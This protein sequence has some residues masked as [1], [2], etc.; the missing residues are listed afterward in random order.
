MRKT[1]CFR[2]NGRYF[3]PVLPILMLKWLDAGCSCQ[4]CKWYWSSYETSSKKTSKFPKC[5][6]I[7]LIKLD[8]RDEK[9]PPNNDVQFVENV[10]VDRRL[11][12]VKKCHVC[13]LQSTTSWF[14]KVPEMKCLDLTSGEVKERKID[15]LSYSQMSGR[16][17]Q[18]NMYPDGT[19]FPH[20]IVSDASHCLSGLRG[21]FVSQKGFKMK[22]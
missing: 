9:R 12:Y 18:K 7:L 21:S 6:T 8:I 16:G 17:L 3:F 15:R 1:F 10:R 11:Y 14:Q 20:S 5:C 13:A 4:T 2:G 19:G 22:A